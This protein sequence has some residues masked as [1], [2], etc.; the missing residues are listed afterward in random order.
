MIKGSTVFQDPPP[1]CSRRSLGCP[2]PDLPVC[3]P[4]YLMCSVVLNADA[5]S[6][7]ASDYSLK[8]AC[9]RKFPGGCIDDKTLEPPSC[10]DGGG[11]EPCV[12]N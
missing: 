3:S 2:S 8:S 10:P 5:G 9:G 1:E 12:S 11:P 4:A 7:T 6:E